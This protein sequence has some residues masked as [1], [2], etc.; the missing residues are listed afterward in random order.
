M[1]TSITQQEMTFEEMYLTY[2]NAVY[3]RIMSRVKQ[4]ETAEDLTQDTFVKAWK[5]WPPAHTGNLRNWLLVIAHYTL[6][7]FF[8]RQK[9]TCT[10]LDPAMDIQEPLP[11]IPNIKQIQRVDHAMA[12]L[13]TPMQSALYTWAASKMTGEMITDYQSVA[14]YRARKRLAQLY[15]Q[16]EVAS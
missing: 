5:H 8:R 6:L 15:T 7:D 3:Y 9:I 2:K 10:S 4:P 12:K 1:D 16:E 14:A 13:S 11:S